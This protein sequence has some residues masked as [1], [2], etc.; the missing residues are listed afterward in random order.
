MAI[1]IIPARSGS[2]RIPRKNIKIFEGKPIIAY[3]IET[4]LETK[5]FERVVV[6]TDSETIAAIAEDYGACSHFRPP[7]YC[8]DYV[9]TQEVVTE[10]IRYNLA[11]TL[12]DTVCCIYAT[13][14]LMSASDLILGHDIL[15]R[16]NRDFVLSVGYPPLRDA[17]QFYW[18][19]SK[20]F[21]GRYP[22]IGLRT[23]MVPIHKARVCDINI[24]EDWELAVKMYRALDDSRS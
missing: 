12:G 24:P 2:R 16:D 9:G 21:A 4:A 20:S 1:A 7:K 14:P 8:E 13:A 10:Y 3:S 19:W 18:G 5:L 11:D 15:I 17:G 23:G 6:S 22:L